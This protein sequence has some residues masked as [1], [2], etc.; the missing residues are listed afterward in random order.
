MDVPTSHA[1][2]LYLYCI[3]IAALL[4]YVPPFA[5]AAWGRLQVGYDLEAPRTMTSKV[6]PYAQRA[7]WAHENSFEA[8]TI[9][10]AAAL[11]AYVTRVESPVGTAAAVA[12]PVVRFLFSIFYIVNLP[13][14]RG[15]M[16]LVGTACSATLMILSILRAAQ[17]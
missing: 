16:Y 10:A 3:A 14:A 6:P 5:V 2:A 17:S 9:F 15:S 11:M 13:L 1:P 7:T 12:F 4:I 8:F